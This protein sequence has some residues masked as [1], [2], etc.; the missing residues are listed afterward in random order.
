MAAKRRTRSPHSGV[1]LERPDPERRRPHWRARFRDPD[2]GKVTKVKLDPAALR[3]AEA[4]RDWAIRK[5]KS[6]TKRRLELEAGAPR[7]TGMP[8]SQAVDQYF[9]DHPEL[10][11][12]TLGLYRQAA[13]KLLGWAVKAGVRSADDLT[14]P[15]L[16]AF[17][18]ELVKEPLRVPVAGG[19]R[20]AMKVTDQRRSAV[21]IN[22]ELRSAR[23]IL[24]YLRK[25]GL[26]PKV[27]SDELTD[28]LERLDEASEAIQ[29]LR[30]PELQRL[31]RAALAHD[32]ETFRVT[33]AEHRGLLPPGSTVKFEPVAPFVAFVL[34]TGMRLAEGLELKWSQV[35][36]DAKDNDGTAVGEIQLTATTK[37]KKARVV[38]LEVSP[39]LRRLLTTMHEQLKGKATVFGLS[40]NA[41]KS[42]AERLRGDYEAPEAYG[43]Q[44]LRHT[45]GT[46]LTCAPGIYG[47]ASAYRSAKQLGHSVAV[48]EKHYLGLVRGIPAT[49]RTLEAAMGIEAELE[50]VIAAVRARAK[51]E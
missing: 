29:Y 19:K 24:G 41:A 3:T 43:W 28:S 20:G 2:T 25:L 38:G 35:D 6:L 13:D 47:A 46:Y 12:G 33:R 45:T 8:V 51:T 49:A 22:R 26:L 1:V 39:A 7:A 31:L 27:T 36:L 44:V 18:A 14:G 23:T 10:R 32:A 15:R 40:R 30:P 37:T 17:R 9:R 50:R 16:V 5:S 4:R 48:A 42:A 11:A 34:L 21:T